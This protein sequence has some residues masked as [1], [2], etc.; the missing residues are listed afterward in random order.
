DS[1]LEELFD[2][3]EEYPDADIIYPNTVRITSDGKEVVN[4]YDNWYENKNILLQG[5]TIEKYFPEWGVLVKK[6]LLQEKPF[7]EEFKD[8]EFYEFLLRNFEKIKPALS[9]ISFVNIYETTSFIDTSYGSKLVRDYIVKKYSLKKIFPHLSWNENENLAQSTAYT[10]IGDAIAEYHD[11]YNAT[12]FYRKALISFHNQHT[13]KKLINA[14]INMGLF[15]NAK[16]LLSEEQGLSKE[17]IQ[18]IKQDV[19]K[20]E[21]LIK[22]L[23]KKVEEGLIDEVMYALNDVIQVYQGAP[24]YNIA[25]VIQFYKGN[26]IDAYRFFYKAVIINPLEENILRNLTD[27]AKRIG[28]ED[29]VVA[30]VN[31]LLK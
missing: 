21:T 4:N 14:Y 22:E 19:E 5:L 7:N 25:G 13:L 3:L 15:E 6:D 8:Y 1:T 29:E 2:V 23:E 18:S 9:E 11:F 16:S 17:E 12:D 30:L 24:I 26:I 27:V 10:M 28:K 20:I 31:R